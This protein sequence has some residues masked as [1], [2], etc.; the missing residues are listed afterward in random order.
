[1]GNPQ[2]RSLTWLAAV[3]ECEGSVSCQVYTLPDGRVRITPFVSF[4]NSDDLLLKRVAELFDEIGV[5]WRNCKHS[6]PTVKP[7]STYRVDG[8]KPVK[9]LL[10]TLLPYMVGE[11]RKYAENVLEFIRSREERLLIRNEKGCIK[12]SPY[13]KR[14]IDLVTEFRT[15][16][17]AKSSETIC[18]APNVVG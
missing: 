16:T 6:T 15:H 18:L 17:R 2:E 9:L 14:E 13:T 4:V 1:M 3:I 10:S 12:R 11:K 8:V 7:V 5:K